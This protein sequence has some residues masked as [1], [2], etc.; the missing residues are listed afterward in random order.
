MMVIDDA[1]TLCLAAH[2]ARESGTCRTEA[3]RATLRERVHHAREVAACLDAYEEELRTGRERGEQV[4]PPLAAGERAERMDYGPPMHARYAELLPCQDPAETCGCAWSIEDPEIEALVAEVACGMSVSPAEALRSVLRDRAVVLR[5][6]A[7]ALRPFGRAESGLRAHV[8]G[9][10]VYLT[11]A[12]VDGP[13]GAR[14]RMTKDEMEEYL[15]YGPH[16]Y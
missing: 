16:G 11:L 3:V 1:E 8:L 7:D 15:G 5:R 10:V 2:V 4:R 9:D 13:D 6:L 14:G 12:P